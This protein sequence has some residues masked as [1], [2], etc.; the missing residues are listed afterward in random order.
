VDFCG[1]SVPGCRH[2][3][4]Q[5]ETGNDDKMCRG[6]IYVMDLCYSGM[7]RT[8]RSGKERNSVYVEKVMLFV[9][10]LRRRPELW[11]AVCDAGCWRYQ[12]RTGNQVDNK[13]CIAM[14]T[15]YCYGDD[16]GRLAI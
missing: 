4:D 6:F 14:L 2:E 1:F 7:L 16:T 9:F 13:M 15:A 12:N 8:S 11:P 5:H 10:P 3:Q